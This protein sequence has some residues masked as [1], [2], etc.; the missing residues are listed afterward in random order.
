MPMRPRG[1]VRPR[2]P[3]SRRDPGNLREP[4]HPRGAIH[5]PDLIHR[6]DPVRLRELIRPP[7]SIRRLIT[8]VIIM[9]PGFTIPMGGIKKFSMIGAAPLQEIPLTALDLE[10]H[11]FVFSPPGD[12]SRLQD[13]IQEIGLLNPPWL[14]VVAGDRFQAVTGFKR[15]LAAVLLG[16]GQV[17]ARILP[18]EAPEAQCLL[19][20]LYDNAF[21]RDFNNL[22]Q[23]LLAS[24][25]LEYWDRET[26]IHK[27]LPFLGLA[28]SFSILERL[29]A[30]ASLEEPLQQLAARGRLA[31]TAAALLA[32]WDREDRD[33]VAPFLEKL[34]FSQS[35][36]E[37]FLQGLDLLARREG[38]RP[39]AIIAREEFRRQVQEDSGTPQA[40]AAALRLGLQKLVSPRFAAAL[41]AFQ[42]GLQRLGLRHHP[43]FLLQPP[44]ALEGPDFHLEIK[45]HDAGELQQLLDELTRLA[46]EEEFATLTRI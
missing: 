39:A 1:A 18:E 22:E 11:S 9:P 34:P 35:K 8:A 29:L 33:A 13:S 15:L 7:E 26:V 40:R 16:W 5:L 21:S 10:D 32:A 42:A 27:F 6:R 25:L 31:L 28:P 23:A 30:L 44:P 36:Q 41:E 12:L 17:A 37:E 3:I 19:V 46:R 38:V 14:R 43:R 20:H 45:F 4:I 2:E 24:R